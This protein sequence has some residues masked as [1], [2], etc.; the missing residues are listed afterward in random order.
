MKKQN[1]ILSFLFL[2]ALV[3]LSSCGDDEV[4]KAN[5]D[6]VRAAF[7]NANTQIS[8]DLN[9]VNSTSGYEA[10][11]QLSVL[12][13]QS[14]PFGRKSSKKRE[15]VIDNFKA[16]IYAIRGM[17][18]RST[19]NARIQEDEAFDFDA[20]KGIYA[21]NVQEQ[22]WVSAGQSQIIE[23]RFPTAGAESAT[24]D[25]VFQLT[26][27]AEALTPNGDQLYSPTVIKASILVDAVKELEL[28]AEVEYGDDD[29]PVKG[30]V[31]YFVNPFAL[32]ISFDDSKAKSSAFSETLSKSGQVLIGFGASVKYNSSEK[33]EEEIT[34]ISAHVQLVDVKLTISAKASDASGEDPYDAVKI[35][36][37][38]NG[39]I[40]GKIFLQ[41]DETTGEPIPYVKYNDGS[42]EPLDNLFPD[43]AFEIQSIFK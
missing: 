36:I 6:E 15:Q 5:K 16:G 28:D 32:E 24:N 8:T 17:L 26:D 30:D 29:Q 3:A 2:T 41:E 20:H 21:W 33:L 12:T 31:Y 14:D 22:T 43:T 7:Q 18:T 10:M 23:I 19:T 25:A 39:K 34:A 35:G 40:G 4:G 9:S 37:K 42:T 11:N 1:L 13:D 38:V 27:Y